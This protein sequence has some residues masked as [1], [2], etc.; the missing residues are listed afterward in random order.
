MDNLADAA[1][2]NLYWG[3]ISVDMRA[4]QN[5]QL[6]REK[7]KPEIIPEQECEF[8]LV[9]ILEFRFFL[10]IFGFQRWRA[11]GDYD[12]LLARKLD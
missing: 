3:K 1:P 5:E 9:P 8:S 11:Y 10:F 6:S 2:R 12:G 7:T 4:Q